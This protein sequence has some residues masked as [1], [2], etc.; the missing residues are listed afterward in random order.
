[1]PASKARS[2]IRCASASS[3]RLPKLIVP[4]PN[5][6][7]ISPLFP[8]R[9]RRMLFHRRSA[10]GCSPALAEINRRF[11]F[12]ECRIDYIGADQ[13]CLRPGILPLQSATGAQTNSK[14]N[15]VRSNAAKKPKRISR[16]V[17]AQRMHRVCR[18]RRGTVRP[19]RFGLLTSHR[20]VRHERD[21]PTP[22]S[23]RSGAP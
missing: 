21:A 9:F 2:R 22:G 16:R 6:D 11:I 23:R 8:R 17:S 3:T 12:L 7:T 18:G 15:R 13:F 1:M 14:F 10:D 20:K 4:S 19:C 5:D